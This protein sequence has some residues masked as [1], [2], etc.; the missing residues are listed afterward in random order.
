MDPFTLLA[1]FSGVSS[2]IGGIGAFKQNKI[3]TQYLNQYMD[4]LNQNKYDMRASHKAKQDAYLGLENIIF[5]KQISN[6]IDYTKYYS[7]EESAQ[8]GPMTGGQKWVSEKKEANEH[9]QSEKGLKRAIDWIRVNWKY[10]AG[11]SPNTKW[12]D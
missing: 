6:P 8:G 5:G 11:T 4:M 9:M 10:R 2:A 7:D 3:S 1:I 12:G